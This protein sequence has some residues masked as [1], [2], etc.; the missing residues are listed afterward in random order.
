VTCAQA[1]STNGRCASPV[2]R[3]AR[4]SCRAMP[5]PPSPCSGHFSKVALSQALL[6]RATSLEQMVRRLLRATGIG[7]VGL[8]RSWSFLGLHRSPVRR[9]TLILETRAS[10]RGQ[11]RSRERIADDNQTDGHKSL[12]E[13]A[14]LPSNQSGF[15][16]F[17]SVASSSSSKISSASPAVCTPSEVSSN[18][19][20]P[21][22]GRWAFGLVGTACA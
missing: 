9:A 19:S 5:Q 3:L 13:A 4:T 1:C 7:L 20:S 12:Q 21:V 22:F 10:G 2:A 11:F 8:K 17:G 6:C 18:S 14:R 15:L 16:R